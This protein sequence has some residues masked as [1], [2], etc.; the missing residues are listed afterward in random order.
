MKEILNFI[1]NEKARYL[2]ELKEFLSIPSISSVP[3][4]KEDCLRCANWLADHIKSIGITDTRVIPTEGH[5]I[6]FAQWLGAGTGKPTILIYG[7]YDVQPVDPLE[8][9][10]NPPFEPTVVN[11][12]IFARGTADDKGQV[13]CH[14]KAIESYFKNNK[15]IPVNIK[16]IIEGEE[17]AGSSNIDKFIQD[18]AELLSCDTVLVSDTEWFA[19]GL[20]SLCY[21]LRG[22]SFVEVT[23]TGPNRDLHSGT[24]GGGV[25][26]P[27]NVLCDMIS[28]LKDKYGRITIP[29]FYDK[30]EPLTDLEKDNYKLLPFNEADYC[31]D[32]DIGGTNGE[33]GYTTLER[34]WARPT[35]DLNGIY[36]G[37]TGVG[38]KTVLPS[39]ASAKISMR[40]VAYQDP[41]EITEKIKN[42]LIAIAP[43]TVKVEVVTLH[44]GKPVLVKLDSPGVRAASEAFFQAFGKK[45]VFM[46]EGGS[47]PVVVEFEEVLKAPTVLMGFGLPSDNIHS[48]NEN[49]DLNNFYGGIRTAALFYNE[50]P[51]F[52]KS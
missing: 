13:F 12:K 35:L 18:N 11:N 34:V 2:T 20:P 16:L 38:A 47:I 49:F 5:P 27:I 44:G 9:W 8:L 17:E 36:G 45:P 31:K 10:T 40:L 33:F 26:N 52:F 7:H 23:V 1:E 32:L 46:R 4:N 39:K 43:L 15:P 42:Y 25:D 14:L 29:G 48:P 6:V 50:F 51:N 22:I 41:A 24:F 3:E 37:Y 19:E 21:A 30:V 28:R